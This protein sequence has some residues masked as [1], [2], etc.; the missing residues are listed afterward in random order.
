MIN[1]ITSKNKVLAFFIKKKI[2]ITK[3]HF[4]SSFKNSLQLGFIIKG[5][6]DKIPL[7]G[8][9]KIIRTIKGTSEILFVKNGSMNISIFDKLKFIKKITLE[10]GDIISLIDCSHKL[11]FNKKTTLIEIKQGPF[12]KNDKINLKEK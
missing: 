4:F 6:N 10:K 11:S 3:T 1:L 7:H 9:K 12:I 8:H 2:K 5:K